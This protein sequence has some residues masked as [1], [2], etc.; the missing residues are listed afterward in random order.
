[1]L[2]IENE[3]LFL[4]AN[5]YSAAE[6]GKTESESSPP[7][8]INNLWIVTH[9]IKTESFLLTTDILFQSIPGVLRY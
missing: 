8:T 5:T 2:V 4:D 9:T 6:T 1:M 3:T 7:I